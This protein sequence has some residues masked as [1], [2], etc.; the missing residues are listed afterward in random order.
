MT[1][2]ALPV[3]IVGA[4]LAGLACARALGQAGI[5]CTVFEAADAVGGRVRTDVVDG[6]RIDRGFQVLLTA[7]PEA[8][9]VLDLA[10]LDLRPF[11]AGALV[12]T[13]G[14]FE[15]VGDPFREPKALVPTL[16]ARVGT[17]ADKVR[18]LGLRASVAR[19]TPES[20]WQRPETTTEAALRTRYG[21]SERMVDRFFRPFLGGVLLDRQLGASSRAFEFYFRMFGEGQ[22][23]VP[24]RGMQAIPEQLASRL[25]AGTVRL[26]APVAHVEP[27]GSGLRLASG[28][29]VACRAVVV[30]TDAAAVP[31]LIPDAAVPA[32]KGTVQIA[33]AADAAPTPA[34]LLM[35]DGE[36]RGPVN[37]AQVM[38]NIAPEVAPA[39]RALVTASV[40]GTPDTSDA[41]LDAAARAQMRGWFGAGVDGWRTL[42]VHRVPHALPDLPSLDPPE[43]PLHVRERLFMTGDWLRNGS[44]DGALVAGRHAAEAVADA[45]R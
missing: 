14:R 21:F 16:F 32:W 7:Y 1:D 6:F 9:A 5:A 2:E 43:R 19:G 22:A 39:G 28:E 44:I 4:G 38:S 24:A 34:R 31:G 8:S 13:G 30:A 18:V 15:H 42:A 37:N 29:T 45:L 12:R 33:W 11:D 35:L 41:A 17:L 3:A 40:L 25:P 23:A 26:N 36:G 10:A 20:L 27:D